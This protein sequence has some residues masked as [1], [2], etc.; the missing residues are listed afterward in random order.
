[1]HVD[2]A[3]QPDPLQGILQNQYVGLV[4]VV[5]AGRL[6][7]QLVLL[8]NLPQDAG[9]QLLVL[10]QRPDDD[11]LLGVVLLQFGQLLDRMFVS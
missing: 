8:G 1:M 10:E 6:R 7:H 4:G 3:L 11:A 9:L 5:R 2:L